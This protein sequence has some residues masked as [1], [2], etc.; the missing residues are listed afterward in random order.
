[1]LKAT[2]KKRTSDRYLRPLREQWLAAVPEQATLLDVGCGTGDFLRLA[3]PK[4]EAGWGIDLDHKLIQYARTSAKEQGLDHLQFTDQGF[5]P[6]NLPPQKVDIASASLFFHVLRWSKAVDLL[7]L[8]AQ[9]G[10]EIWVAA[11]EP[12]QRWQEKVSLWLD[13]RFSGH[14][15]HYQTY[16]AEGGMEAL[17]EATGLHT[18][19][20]ET[21]FDRSIA[22]Y[23]LEGK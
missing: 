16:M 23:Q 3:G 6:N 2:W 7:K 22:W 5:S 1:M 10:S 15:F 4:L 11:L 12:P 8:L 21:T 14:F 9:C 13:Q 17:I 18:L 19:E 20:K